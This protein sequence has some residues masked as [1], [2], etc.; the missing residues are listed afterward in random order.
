MNIVKIW[1]DDNNNVMGYDNWSFDFDEC[2]IL[3]Y[4]VVFKVYDMFCWMWIGY[5]K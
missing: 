2:V 1:E 3:V 5:N 4:C